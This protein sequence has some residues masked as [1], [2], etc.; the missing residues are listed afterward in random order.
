MPRLVCL[1]PID[2]LLIHFCASY[3]GS[4]KSPDNAAAYAIA[5]RTSEYD[6][7]PELLDDIVGRTVSGFSGS[8]DSYGGGGGDGGRGG[9]RK[10]GRVDE[11]EEDE[12]LYD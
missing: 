6:L 8:G 9:A 2:P 3:L 5:V 1:A 12:S 11:E 7:P 10:R 4:V